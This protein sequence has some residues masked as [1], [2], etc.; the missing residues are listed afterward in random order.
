VCAAAVAAAADL[1]LRGRHGRRGGRRFMVRRVALAGGHAGNEER[2]GES[3]SGHAALQS[4]GWS[5]FDALALPR[6][7]RAFEGASSGPQ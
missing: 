1:A 6:I 7:S 4:K 5:T 2:E 3:T